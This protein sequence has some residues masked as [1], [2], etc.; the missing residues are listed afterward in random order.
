MV[1]VGSARYIPIMNIAAFDKLAYVDALKAGGV[2]EEQARAHANALDSAMRES[3]ATKA[4]LDN[5]AVKLRAEVKSD[6]S[7]LKADLTMRMVM[8]L[9]GQAGLVIAIIKFL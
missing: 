5:L 1:R 8:L 3:V 2:G 4:D 6:M 7:E 9:L